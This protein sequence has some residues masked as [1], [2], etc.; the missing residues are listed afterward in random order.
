MGWGSFDCS[1]N[2][3][4]CSRTIRTCSV[5]S[6]I[7]FVQSRCIFSAKHPTKNAHSPAP[8][9]RNKSFALLR[10]LPMQEVVYG[11]WR[12]LRRLQKQTK[13]GGSY[14]LPTSSFS[15]GDIH[16]SM[17][18]LFST[19][20]RATSG[21]PCNSGDANLNMPPLRSIVAK[22]M[23]LQ[24]R[25]SSGASLKGVGSSFDR[26]NLHCSD[27]IHVGNVMFWLHENFGTFGHTR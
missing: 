19:A 27:G 6:T 15:V 12:V 14:Q 7:R 11:K 13:E 18:I 3:P 9:L 5:T 22:A 10:L 25:S 2:Q 1:F 17:P 4:H 8:L 20:T 23:T 24:P 26:D 21:S 16:V